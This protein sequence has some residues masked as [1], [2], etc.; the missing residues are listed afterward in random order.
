MHESL[1]AVV[2]AYNEAG[3]LADVVREIVGALIATGRSWEVILVDDGSSDGTGALADR[4]AGELAGV[5]VIHHPDNGGLGAVYRTGFREAR[6]DLVTFFPADGQFPA[7]IIGDFLPRIEEAD[8]VL[9]YLE[10]RRDPWTAKILSW[11]ERLLYRLLFGPLPRFQGVF[12]L[13][14][15]VLAELPLTSRG[16]GWT[17]VME[18]LVRARRAGC[19]LESVP[20]VMRP[21]QAGASKV[22]NLRTVAANLLELARLRR[23]L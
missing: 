2:M 18:L 21:R 11:G 15:R 6:S 16:R 19:R 3:S 17:V 8:M 4:L 12:L 23:T 10:G 22:R 9:G 20:T 14:R 7:T 5:R 13:R 1:T